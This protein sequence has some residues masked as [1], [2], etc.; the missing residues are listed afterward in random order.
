MHQTGSA[1]LPD[2]LERFSDV[3]NEEERREILDLQEQPLQI[4]IRINPL[5]SE[6]TQAMQELATRYGW[7]I[8]PLTY[9]ENGWRIQNPE[10][11]PG[12]TIEHR[13]GQY[14]LQDPASMVPASLLSIDHPPPLILDMAASPGGK[15]THLMDR[16][17]DRGFILANDASQSRIGA[18][19]AVLSNWGGINQAIVNFPGENFGAWYPEAFDQVLLDAPCSMENLRPTS[20]QPMRETT[21]DERL[22]LQERQI[23]LLKSGLQA[24]KTGGQLVYATCSLAPEEDEAVID[25]ILH[26]FSDA[27][28]LEDVRDKIGFDARGLISF[29]GKSFHPSL[30][31]ALRL[32]PH[33]TG[34]SGFFC[35]LLTKTQSIPID[36]DDPPRRDFAR[37]NLEPLRS[38][39]RHSLSQQLIKQYGFDLEAVFEKYEVL[40]YRRFEQYFLIPRRYIENFSTL[41]YAYIGMPLGSWQDDVFQPSHTFVSRFGS[42]FT[43][44][45][46]VLEDDKIQQWVKGRDIRYPDTD[47]TPKGQFLLVKD[48]DNRNLGLGKLLP[49]RLRNLLPRYLI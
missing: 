37:T 24:L 29:Q 36:Y 27:I 4:G 12:T 9:C 45:T 14:Y 18:L 32:W 10:K 6:P 31:K 2:S 17:C 35:C 46:I 38:D 3:L 42:Q 7:D 1:S 22:R 25:S 33:R 19:R 49:K 15:T 28:Q 26:Q 20:D 47:L 39:H 30:S 44:G 11:S 43:F 13:M 21:G 5:K 41:P 8:Q 16:T 23:Q 34:F 48:E 40:P